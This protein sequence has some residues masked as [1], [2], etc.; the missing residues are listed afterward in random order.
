MSAPRDRRDGLEVT[1]R[2]WIYFCALL[3]VVALLSGPAAPVWLGALVVVLVLVDRF[4][5][6]E[7]ALR[8]QEIVPPV[9]FPLGL[10][11][12]PASREALVCPFCKDAVGAASEHVECT[13]CGTWHHA[14]CFQEYSGCA[15]FG[16]GEQRS[17]EGE[18]VA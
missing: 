12:A 18:R 11:V 1:G 14:A 3:G 16:C 2:G 6:H 17:R 9:A 7:A 13:K 5:S 4:Q 15:V 8:N 10:D